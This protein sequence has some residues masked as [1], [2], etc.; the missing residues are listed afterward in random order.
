MQALE[1][2]EITVFNPDKNFKLLAP[3]ARE[4]RDDK[5]G[6]LE[7]IL[8]QLLCGKVREQQVLIDGHT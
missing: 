5:N 7:M 4:D 6:V 2:N 8:M 1:R 3:N